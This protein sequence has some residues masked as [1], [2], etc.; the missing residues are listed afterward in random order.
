MLFERQKTRTYCSWSSNTKSSTLDC[1]KPHDHTKKS[2]TFVL[3]SWI[4]STEVFFILLQFF[5]ILKKTQTGSEKSVNLD[6][7]AAF[8]C[9]QIF[10]KLF[11]FIINIKSFWD[12]TG[13]FMTS[14]INFSLLEVIISKYTLNSCVTGCWLKSTLIKFGFGFILYLHVIYTMIK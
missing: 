1:N 2:V 5:L 4:K 11:N 8:S 7:P 9:S 14:K 6:R 3:P 12:N 13:N 10:N